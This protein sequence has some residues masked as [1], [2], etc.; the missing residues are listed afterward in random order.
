M[1][2]SIRMSVDCTFNVHITNLAKHCTNLTGNILKTFISRD[3]VTML[4]LYAALV[5]LS[6]NFIVYGLPRKYKINQVSK[7]SSIIYRTYLAG[8]HHKTSPMMGILSI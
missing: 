1:D 7:E 4:T 8:M 5:L 6:L 3:K 2:L